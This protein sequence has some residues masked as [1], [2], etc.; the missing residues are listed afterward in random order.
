M[1]VY[2]CLCLFMFKFKVVLDLIVVYV[3]DVVDVDVYMDLYALYT[4][5]RYQ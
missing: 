1:I 5:R 2:V 3:D 4:L